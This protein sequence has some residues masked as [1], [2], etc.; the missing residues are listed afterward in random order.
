MLEGSLWSNLFFYS[1]P[2]MCSQILEVLFNLSDVAVVGKFASY[3]ALG[4][5]GSTSILVTLF[6]SFV[7]GMGSGVTVCVAHKIG[8]Q[9][10]EG[11]KKAVTSSFY[12]CVAT[13]AII[14]LSCLCSAGFFLRLLHTKEELFA[15][16]VLYLRIYALGLPGMAIYTFGS[17]VLS[18]KGE[19]KRPLMY[20]TFSGILNVILN[21]FFVIIC[22]RAADGVAMASAISQYVSAGLV[23]Y[24]LLHREDHCKFHVSLSNMD[25]DISKHIVSIGLP[26][27]LQNAVFA[28]ANLFVQMSVNS[29]D[30][31][32]VSGNAAAQ[33]AD[34]IIFNLMAA[35]Y[36]GCSGFISCNYGAGN[37]DRML[38]SY[39]IALLYSVLAGLI[40]GGLLFVFGR[41]FL[42]LFTSEEMVIQAGMQRVKI[43][44]LAYML[45][46]FMDCSIAASRGLGKSIVPMIIVLMGSCVF[47]VFWIYTVF[48]HF[49]TI[50]SL[51]LLYPVSW[52]IT[53]IAEIID[54]VYN[55]R[56]T[57]KE[58]A[59]TD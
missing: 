28:V 53:G 13:G 8:S 19:T 32:M 45:S 10:E 22:G 48:A 35:F 56:K 12:V 37:K 27:G 50:P 21:L 46:G 4:A 36:T 57:V 3:T 43:M 16:A 55:Y 25:K 5:V 14:G 15:Q 33:N 47:R 34:T 39:F 24:H 41:E 59:C 30:A 11:V 38:K 23:V 40:A 29:F 18:A 20:L 2:L 17:G 6:I 1:I 31:V 42:S 58:M 44:G 49:H 52:T 54:F 26:T 7:I 51:Y 9:D